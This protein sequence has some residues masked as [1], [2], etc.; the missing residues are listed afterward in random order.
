VEYTHPAKNNKE[1]DYDNNL[2]WTDAE[3]QTALLSQDIR[4]YKLWEK[5]NHCLQD[6]FG[7]KP[8]KNDSKADVHL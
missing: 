4:R 3:K 6:E 7:W 1:F 8:R 5:V 2:C